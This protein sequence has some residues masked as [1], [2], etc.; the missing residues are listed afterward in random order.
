MESSLKKPAGKQT[1]SSKPAEKEQA[2]PIQGVALS[3]LETLPVDRSSTTHAVCKYVKKATQDIDGNRS[4][5]AMLLANDQTKRL[6]KDVAETFVSYA[7]NGEWGATL[8][9]LRRRKAQL[10]K[11]ELFVWM[12][13]FLVDQHRAGTGMLAFKDW[14]QVFQSSLERIG[15]AT[16]VLSPGHEPIATKRAWCCFEWTVIR[17]SNI[18]FT[19]LVPESDEQHIIDLMKRGMGFDDFYNLFSKINVENAEAYKQED[20]DQILAFLRQVG[21]LES[22][23]L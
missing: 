20:K 12:D 8:D 11:D 19:C 2:F 18:S 9:V 4:L 3:Y 21:V 15:N 23:I 13:V 5:A 16:L 14:S 22:T 17:K 10:N 1:S 7:W 6:V